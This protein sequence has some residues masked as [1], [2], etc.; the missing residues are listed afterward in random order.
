[1]T[2]TGD[3]FGLRQR[4]VYLN[5]IRRPL[6]RLVSHYYFLRY[7]DDFRP[8]LV[9]TRA[10]DTEVSS[11]TGRWDHETRTPL[12][13][14]RGWQCPAWDACGGADIVIRST[15]FAYGRFAVSMHG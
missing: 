10:G 9:R 13:Q 6:D 3:R 5:L 7:G 8:H 4:P 1:M 11:E 12:L 14:P 15:R 2:V